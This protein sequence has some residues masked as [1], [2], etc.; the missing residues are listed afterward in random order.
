MFAAVGAHRSPDLTQIRDCPSL[1]RT[2]PHLAEDRKDQPSQDG[3][4]HDHDEEFDQREG[5]WNGFAW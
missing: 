2:S 1:E 4:D 5:G 3:D